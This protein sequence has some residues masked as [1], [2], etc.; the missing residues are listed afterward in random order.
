MVR[1]AVAGA[2]AGHAVRVLAVAAALVLGLAAGAAVILEDLVLVSGGAHRSYQG[3]MAIRAFRRA[4]ASSGGQ[5]SQAR[6]RREARAELSLPAKAMPRVLRTG[7]ATGVLR[8]KG[9]KRA[10]TYELVSA[11]AAPHPAKKP[12][13]VAGKGKKA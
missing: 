4:S 11:S 3:L 13:K 9:Q 8:S 10:T 6:M 5:S 2:P 12:A 1:D 7:L